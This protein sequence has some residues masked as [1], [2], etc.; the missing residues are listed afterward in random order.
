M[1]F[2]VL[3]FLVVDGATISFSSSELS[4]GEV[5][6]NCAGFVRFLA[7]ATTGSSS[8]LTMIGEVALRLGARRGF[9]GSSGSVSAAPFGA[10]RNARWNFFARGIFDGLGEM[11]MVSG[12]GSGSD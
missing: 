7:E 3:R 5:R 12:S 9:V 1:G 6:A 2:R 4:E 11:L 8:S 10:K